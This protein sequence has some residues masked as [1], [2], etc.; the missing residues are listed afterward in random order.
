MKNFLLVLTTLLL[1]DCTSDIESDEKEILVSTESDSL[2]VNYSIDTTN[3]TALE[4]DSFPD[5]LD[6]KPIKSIQT[7]P[8]SI[9]KSVQVKHG[10]DSVYD[11]YS[12]QSQ[13]F[14]VN[15]EQSS[16]IE[17]NKGTSIYIPQD[18]FG[19]RKKV[20]IK[21]KESNSKASYLFDCLSTQTADGHQLETA[22]MIKIEAFDLNGNPINLAKGKEL[23][24]HFP[25]VGA[26][27]TGF[28][29]F[30]QSIS[31]DS[32]VEWK[33]NVDGIKDFY[34]HRLAFS[35]R[36][37]IW[38][39]GIKKDTFPYLTSY[40]I[41]FLQTT[42]KNLVTNR[43]EFLLQVSD[44]ND[45]IF[46]F[47]E[48]N[49]VGNI[50]LLNLIKKIINHNSFRLL[51]NKLK[52]E[53]FPFRI[54]PMFSNGGIPFSNE[55]YKKRFIEK[56]G[57]GDEKKAK[58]FELRNYV[59]RTNQLGWINC[60]RFYNDPRT[61]VNLNILANSTNEDYMLYFKDFQSAIRAKKVNKR[62]VIKDIPK[63]APAT[64]LGIKYEDGKIFLGKKDLK[65]STKPIE[66]MR[67]KEVSFEN[68]N[69]KIKELVN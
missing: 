58:D 49:N 48:I 60:D 4:K 55:E 3:S 22:G 37:E 24:L 28:R 54:Y 14:V 47:T 51:T 56:Y 45:S 66:K 46:S 36:G 17:G 26:N 41:D 52:P 12:T 34:F 64:L 15:T 30:N 57:N 32:I 11:S 39:Q 40:E 65:V 59:L 31:K 53:D 63:G 18:A 21:L 67:F 9:V 27:E 13:K 29:I 42:L 44:W 69:A 68:L 38:E 7:N 50:Q 62:S 5:S 8:Q 10:L 1:V 61:K 35:V 25:K 19:E 33:E 23:T 6:T 20:M 43:A 16:F 2:K